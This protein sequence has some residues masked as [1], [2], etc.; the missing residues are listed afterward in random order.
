MLKLSQDKK[1]NCPEPILVV[2][3]GNNAGWDKFVGIYV[4]NKEVIMYEQ[5]SL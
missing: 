2:I 4:N 1:L 3:G 5:N